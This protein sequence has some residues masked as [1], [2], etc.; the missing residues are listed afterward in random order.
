[1]VTP[2]EY[3]PARSLALQRSVSS[4]LM[5]ADIRLKG[6]DVWI[7]DEKEVWVLAEMVRQDETILTVRRKDTGKILEI[8]QVGAL[9]V[10]LRSYSHK[11]TIYTQHRSIAIAQRAF[12]DERVTSSHVKIPTR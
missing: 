8:D 9:L 10:V 4:R 7:E 1:M 6:E 5:R 2:S 11:V 3:M 12:Y